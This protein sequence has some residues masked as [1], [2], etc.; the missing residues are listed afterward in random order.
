MCHHAGFSLG[1]QGLHSLN[2]YNSALARCG[3]AHLDDSRSRR[4]SEFE[5][6]LVYVVRLCLNNDDN[7]NALYAIFPE[8][9][10]SILTGL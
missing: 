2:I 10:S 4:A 9:I 8:L 5:A 3:G 6:N 1:F 7:N